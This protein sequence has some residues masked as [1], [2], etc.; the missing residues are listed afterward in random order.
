MFGAI[1]ASLS[2]KERAAFAVA[3][4]VFLAA[5]VLSVSNYITNNAYYV[6]AY[7][8]EWREGVVGQPVFVNPI[9]PTTQADQDISGL[10]FAKLGD[11]TDAITQVSPTTWDVHLK[12]GLKWQDGAPITADYIVFTVNTIEDP[13]A[14]SPLFASYQ[15]VR[16]SRLSELAVS[17]TIPT[18]YVFFAQ[19]HIEN[20][21]IMP[22]HIFSG[23]PSQNMK[24]SQYGLSPIGSGPYKVEYYSHS[25]NGFITSIY[26]SRNNYY[27]GQK[28]YISNIV[29]KFYENTNDA[30]AA[31]N[32]GSIDGFDL[33]TSNLLPS[34]TLRHETHLL[35]SSRY[36]AV[37]IKQGVGTSL[38]KLSVRRAL[39]GTV[40]K[41][42][43]V[44]TLFGG[45]ATP[46]Y[47][48]TT[49]TPN[50]NTSF[51]PSL[52]NGLNLTLTVPN[53]QFLI[54]TANELQRDWQSY[55]AT[56]TINIVN[57]GDMANKVL[58]GNNYELLLFGNIVKITQDLFSF[59]DSSQYPY[60][61]QNL[62]LYS[63]RGVDNLLADYRSNPNPS[64]RANDLSEASGIIA[65][66]V[67][68]VFL[69]SPEYVYISSPNLHGFSDSKVINTSADM[70]SDIS[71]WYIK[72]RMIL[73]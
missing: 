61:G 37:F 36:Y 25:N 31:F 55:G 2:R 19:D 43:L 53:D 8:G 44:N 65:Q 21:E 40:D 12:Q 16:V 29:I 6:P 68:A 51:N 42:R 4:I 3:C 71:N 73:K 7:G 5:A 34:V 1:F 62:S 64:A 57:S 28:P 45:D 9:L 32:S 24:L 52:L 58:K 35:P 30:I 67:P 39:D 69:Y 59:W 26:L 49:S 46:L 50:T 23:I 13:N 66:S 17:F 38:A 56:T 11:M 47:G 54:D 63:N 15:G 10:I 22:A 72:T 18:P 27:F 14:G 70:F 20:L 48:P 60:P 33:P 41:T